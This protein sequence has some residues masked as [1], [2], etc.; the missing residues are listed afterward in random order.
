LALRPLSPR[1][2]RAKGRPGTRSIGAGAGSAETVSGPHAHPRRSRAPAEAR[3]ARS[4]DRPPRRQPAHGPGRAREPASGGGPGGGG[5]CSRRG[6]AAR[7]VLHEDG[8]SHRQQGSLPAFPELDFRSGARVEELNKLIQEFTKHDQREYD[9]QRALEIHTAKDFI[10]SMLGKEEKGGGVCVCVCVC[11][12]NG[13]RSGQPILPSRSLF[14]LA[15]GIPGV[16]PLFRRLPSFSAASRA[17][18]PPFLTALCAGCPFSPAIAG[19]FVN[20]STLGLAGR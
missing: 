2:A 12:C 18:F 6:A 7:R 1:P 14:F 9:D 19:S 15:P 8:G 4:G 11:V 13:K 16:T 3:S 17:G 10:F 5:G 20:I